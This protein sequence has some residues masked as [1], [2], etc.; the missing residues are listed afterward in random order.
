MYNFYTSL[1]FT[2][3]RLQGAVGCG[4]G[5]HCEKLDFIL[6]CKPG[7]FRSHGAVKSESGETCYCNV[8]RTEKSCGRNY[9]VA[10]EHGNS[11]TEV[12]VIARR[13][14][15]R[16]NYKVSKSFYNVQIFREISGR[17]THYALVHSSATL[18]VC[19]W[20]PTGTCEVIWVF[21]HREGIR[22]KTADIRRKGKL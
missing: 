13:I 19:E 8:R 1:L 4:R 16:Q 12:P 15:T 17:Q 22:A 21:S 9:I 6:G 5:F 14:R 18:S 2:C 11:S 20:T 3:K 10:A 7:I